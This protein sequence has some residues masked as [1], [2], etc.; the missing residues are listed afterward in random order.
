[1]WGELRSIITMA[2]RVWGVLGRAERWALFFAFMVMLVTGTLTSIPPV[3]L[4]QLVD[5]VLKA[6]T[7]D[8]FKA[9]PFILVIIA[10]ILAREALQVLR[11]YLVENACTQVAKAKMIGVI[12]HVLQLDLSCFGPD[13]KVGALHGRIHRSIDG[14]VKM[15]KLCFLDFFPAGVTSLCALGAVMMKN[16]FIALTMGLVIPCGLFIVLRQI[17]TQKGIRLHLLRAKEEI[18]GKVVELLGGIEYVRTANTEAHETQRIEHTAERL[19][20]T[21]IQH[22]IRMAIY[23]AAKYLN[24]GA[25]HIIVLC[26]SIYLTSR[27][28]I[29]IGDVL[30]YSLL[31]SSVVN[32]LREVHRILDE[33]H[34][35]S[36]RV[37]DLFD[38]W[39]K[40]ID[41]SY[42]V[43]KTQAQLPV[44]HAGVPHIEVKDLRFGYPGSNGSGPVLDNINLTIMPGQ[45]VGIA[46]PSGS[47]KSTWIKLLIRL[48]HPEEGAVLVNGRAISTMTREEI[49][50]EFGY[51]SQTPFLLSGSIE[52]DIR[53]GCGAVLVEQI[54]EAAK[55]AN[56]HDEIMAMPGGYQAFVSEKG[57]NLSGGQRQRIAIARMFL[58]NPPVLLLDEATSALD[59]RNEQ[60]VQDALTEVMKDRTVITVAHRLSTLRTTDKILVFQDG[61]IVEEGSYEE[62]LDRGGVFASLDQAARVRVHPAEWRQ[63]RG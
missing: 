8:F 36:L 17:S 55:R 13:M 57:A 30:M 56:I 60:L 49:T 31:F 45:K 16:P 41:R 44:A 38:L 14:F 32:P 40:P 63:P 53:Y 20:R 25:F 35:S 5:K 39:E 46:G 29:S 37:A 24:E 28:A 52:E 47:G 50:R 51:V 23:D 43:S 11:K 34:E 2:T 18:D 1:M 62:L 42:K 9:I 19:R 61:R 12:A 4:G 58:K 33:A 21:E 6:G 10:V 27:G 22:H 15:I 3:V 54:V 7:L 48:L 59:N 26:L